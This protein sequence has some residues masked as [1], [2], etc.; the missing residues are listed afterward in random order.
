MIDWRQTVAGFETRN[1]AVLGSTGSI[2]TQTLEA[3]ELLGVGVC[4]LTANR[5]TSLLEQQARRFNPKAV[6]M[7]D[8]DSAADLRVRL[9][10]TDI[11]VLS[12]EAGVTEA[13]SAPEADTVVTAVVGVAGLKPTMAAIAAGKRIALANKETLVCAGDHV[14]AAAE[15]SGSEII[16]V[17]SEHS[18]V[19]QCLQ[20]SGGNPVRSIIL[21]ASGG[22][23]RG[24]TYGELSKVT[25]AMA[26]RNPNWDMGAKVTIDSAT[27]MNKGLEVIEAMHLFSVKPDMIRV[28]VH[29]QSIVHSMVEF[30]DG[31]VAAQMAVPDMRLPI[32][33][34]LTYPK[35]CPSLAAR[36]DLAHTAALTFEE[37]DLMVFRCLALALDT[38]RRGEKAC[39]VMNAANEV[40]V[41]M[42]LEGRI[43]FNGIYELTEKV[44]ERA[45]LAGDPSLGDILDAD[46]EARRLACEAV[47]EIQCI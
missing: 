4:A 21:T 24:M 8:E 16:P 12:G 35:R 26:L 9:A 37:P 1:I 2:G 31:S 33:Y 7:R 30:C 29:P 41:Q 23:F 20:G 18:A 13:A 38:A 36:L 10:D 19:F 47:K 34:A 46:A 14:T 25:P 15:A 39:A 45:Q 42:F 6:A 28:L 22:P 32:Q 17:D 3:A 11:K 27:M 5:S 44:L 43:G 40:A